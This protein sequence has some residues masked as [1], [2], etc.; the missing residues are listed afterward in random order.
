MAELKNQE[1]FA[2]GKWNGKVFKQS[3]LEQIA[4]TFA[5][6]R[7]VHQVPLKFGH[8]EEQPALDGQPALGWVQRVFVKGKKLIADFTNVP[9]LV[10]EAFKKKL[11]RTVSI[12][13]LLD[14]TH[15]GITFPFV[16]DAVALLGA[17]QPA[18]NTLADL[19][20]LMARTEFSGGGLLTFNTVAGERLD[21]GGN[22]TILDLDDE[23]DEFDMDK[24][25]VKSMIADAIKPLND[26]IETLNADNK[27]V[28]KQRD[29]FEAQNKK[30]VADEEQ[31]T[32]DEGKNKIEL[33]R[34]KV[35][36]QLEKAVKDKVI[37]PAQREVFS[38]V[39][40]VEN[41]EAVVDIE[42]K[43]VD[44][45]IKN[46]TGKT[47]GASEQGLSRDPNLDSGILDDIKD[48]GGK[49]VAMTKELQA[50]DPKLE[51]TA[52]FRRICGANPKLHRE[53]LDSNGEV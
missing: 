34:K 8:N 28:T 32:K 19:K 7:G 27:K 6:L 16:L 12:E 3:D 10:I 53:Y 26:Q 52:G 29:D 22:N 14:V 1:I 42:E 39:L 37:S 41:D 25:D 31:R 30:F 40:R 11:Y 20:T 21:E 48:P 45:L 35:T 51:F 44:E 49:L 36:E 24:D 15:K 38:K 43:D 9:D 33:A 46:A 23:E 47:P 4:H 18:V 13:L 2:A 50:K 5:R 17:D